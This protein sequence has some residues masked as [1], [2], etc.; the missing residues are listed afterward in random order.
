[1]QCHFGSRALFPCTALNF[2]EY[3]RG[4]KQ[5]RERSECM[6]AWAA[7]GRP[8]LLQGH[9]DWEARRRGQSAWTQDFSLSAKSNGPRAEGVQNAAW[10][11]GGEI[12]TWQAFRLPRQTPLCVQKTCEDCRLWEKRPASEDWEKEGADLEELHDF[13][14]SLYYSLKAQIKMDL[15]ELAEPNG[16]LHG[17]RF[18]LPEQALKDRLMQRVQDIVTASLSQSISHHQP[19]LFPVPEIANKDSDHAA[20]ILRACSQSA[21]HGG[22]LFVKC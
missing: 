11:R 21:S 4:G 7:G 18:K 8:R 9:G 22:I 16:T 10:S 20:L 6:V 13:A 2:R 17:E 3:P 14:L 19:K 15:T 1:M 5:G 12:G